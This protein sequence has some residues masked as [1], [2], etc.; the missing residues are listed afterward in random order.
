M[1]QGQSCE[2]SLQGGIGKYNRGVARFRPRTIDQG[3]CEVGH[4][5]AVQLDNISD[6]LVNVHAAP[7]TK[8]RWVGIAQMDP[9]Q[10]RT[11]GGKSPKDCGG[12]VAGT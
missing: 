3:R 4:R 8:P 1:Q 6:E 9:R 12:D 2:L 7:G 5:Q 10:V 11:E